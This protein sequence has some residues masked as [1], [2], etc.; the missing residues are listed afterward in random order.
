MLLSYW[1][2]YRFC[3]FVSSPLS[4]KRASRCLLEYFLVS[5]SWRTLKSLNS[6]PP[7]PTG[8][9]H[10]S[11]TDEA[12]T[13]DVRLGASGMD[14]CLASGGL[15]EQNILRQC[16]DFIFSLKS[17]LNTAGILLT[18]EHVKYHY[19]WV[20]SFLWLTAR[21]INQSI[22]NNKYNIDLNQISGIYLEYGI[23]YLNTKLNNK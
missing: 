19:L 12:L 8:A 1:Q 18:S 17:I 13:D 2:Q 15:I 10:N 16:I 21:Q 14:G 7:E 20:I 9:W 5:I 11:S 23:A 4:T 6:T 3:F 22:K